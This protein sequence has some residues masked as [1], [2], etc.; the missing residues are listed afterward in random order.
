MYIKVYKFI[1]VEVCDLVPD[2]PASL[3]DLDFHV[4]EL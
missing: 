2:F 4:S 3:V 1:L